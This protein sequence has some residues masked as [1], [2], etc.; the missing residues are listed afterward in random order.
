MT[1]ISLN[2][3]RHRETVRESAGIRVGASC[4]SSS[5]SGR[6]PVARKTYF[7]DRVSFAHSLR[8]RAASR[9]SARATG[10]CFWSVQ[11]RFIQR[12]VEVRCSQCIQLFF[13]HWNKFFCG[14]EIGGSY[15]SSLF[16]IGRIYNNINVL[17][18][19]RY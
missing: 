14:E 10:K 4:P 17:T 13:A 18:L 8:R 11:R 5:H 6:R 1:G 3:H 16:A 12:Q 19:C 7:C 9:C 2:L 15:A